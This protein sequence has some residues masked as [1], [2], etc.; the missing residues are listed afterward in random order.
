MKVQG[1]TLE[2][3]QRGRVLPTFHQTSSDA[4]RSTPGRPPPL[5]VVLCNNGQTTMV[6]H[7]TFSLVTDY[8]HLTD[9]T[10]VLA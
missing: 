9:S 8:L 7:V 6:N 3:G 5:A 10:L 2:Q 1:T 4:P